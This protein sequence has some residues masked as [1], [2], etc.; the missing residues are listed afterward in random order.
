MTQTWLAANGEVAFFPILYIIGPIHWIRHVFQVDVVGVAGWQ[1]SA[2][3]WF[4]RSELVHLVKR[5]RCSGLLDGCH[6]C[7]GYWLWIETH[8]SKGGVETGEELANLPLEVEQLASGFILSWFHYLVNH[9]PDWQSLS[10]WNVTEITDPSINIM[11]MGLSFKS[12][13]W[14]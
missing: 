5:G 10:Y 11:F 6:G 3:K 4:A 2:R 14:N 12:I 7:H 8:P 1:W 9:R 13:L